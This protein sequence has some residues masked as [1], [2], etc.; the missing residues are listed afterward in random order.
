MDV[1]M[2][3]G[4]RGMFTLY[5]GDVISS[6]VIQKLPQTGITHHSSAYTAD[7]R[8]RRQTALKAWLHWATSVLSASHYTNTAGPDTTASTHC[9][10][11]LQYSSY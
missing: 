5:S 10:Q 7:D 9:K 2:A 3:T 1:R 6:P 8:S 4:I 11:P